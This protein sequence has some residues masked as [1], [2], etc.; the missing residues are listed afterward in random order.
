M[1]LI[2]RNQAKNIYRYSTGRPIVTPS[3]GSATLGIDDVKVAREWLQFRDSWNDSELVI[4]FEK[5]F[6]DWNGSR[7]AFAFMGG[8][9]ALSAC[10]YALGL[11]EEDEVI[12]PGYTCVVV[13]NAFHYAGVKTVYSDIELETY[14]L[15]VNQIEDKISSKTKAIL[16]QHLYGLVCRDYEAIIDLAKRYKLMVIEDCAHAAGAEFFTKKVGNLGDCAFYSSEQSKVFT[17]IQGGLAVTNNEE[18]A[19]RLEEYY[20]NAPLPDAKWIDKQLHNVILNYYRFKHP[21]R[22]WLG[23]YFLLKYRRKLVIS[24]TKEEENGIRPSYYGRRMP[25]P[26]AAVGLNQLKKIDYY[27]AIR[28]ETA[29]HWDDWSSERGYKLPFVVPGSIPVYLRYP[30]IVEPEKKKNT[31]WSYKDLG[32][33]VGVW[34]V[35]HLHPA[36]RKVYGCKN[37]DVAVRQCINLPG[38]LE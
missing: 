2:L 31:R 36:K 21:Q 32:L 33:R 8:R 19:G 16:I 28:R 24:T 38:V 27:N 18:I 11:R 34:F 26:I 25:A 20:S 30:I 35:S 23:D 10:I 4:E 6:A 7:F 9:V 29:K 3:L 17:T 15:D 1:Y 5:K 14:G 37:A 12:L 13:P 22:W